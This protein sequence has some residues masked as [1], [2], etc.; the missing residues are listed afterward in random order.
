MSH[1]YMTLH[2][3][4]TSGT[5]LG[6]EAQVGIRIFPR[7]VAGG[8]FGPY[9][10]FDRAYEV[11][12]GF[13]TADGTDFA[14]TVNWTASATS[15]PTSTI[16]LAQQEA[17][18]KVFQTFAL[19][20]KALNPMGFAWHSVK[21][22][23]IYPVMVGKPTGKYA[24]PAS[25]FAFKTPL[26]GVI[27]APTSAMPPQDAVC[28]SLRSPVV[29]RAGRGRMYVP[30]LTQAALDGGLVHATTRTTLANAGKALVQGIHALS[31]GVD[32][33]YQVVVCSAGSARGVPPRE[34]RVGDEWDTQRRRENKRGEI[35]TS[36]SL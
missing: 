9:V 32:S 15:A 35:Y 28:V 11:T 26:A 34:V 3:H 1:L 21:L 16:G 17:L 4:Y 29:G 5:W 31:F 14:S 23:P 2:G 20:V 33:S 12:E 22:A 18:A 8:S 13:H 24:A 30:A 7:H 27:T 6:E 36:L 19:T 10:D 25:V